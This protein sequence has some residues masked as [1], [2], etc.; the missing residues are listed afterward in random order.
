[1]ISLSD[2]VPPSVPFRCFTYPK[3]LLYGTSPSVSDPSLPLLSVPRSMNRKSTYIVPHESVPNPM[4]P[5]YTCD[6]ATVV[7]NHVCNMVIMSEI[8]GYAQSNT[9]ALIL[10]NHN[11][12]PIPPNQPALWHYPYSGL[13]SPILLLTPN[14]SS[15][16]W[17]FCSCLPPIPLIPPES[18]GVSLYPPHSIGS[19]PLFPLISST[20]RHSFKNS[21][22]TRIILISPLFP[23][24][25]LPIL[26]RAWLCELAQPCIAMHSH[27]QPYVSIRT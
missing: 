14:S 19:L 13:H 26:F 27:A 17:G 16:I 11:T 10:S 20:I 7:M 15:I 22:S 8:K 4:A 25:I 2:S 12:S 21:F 9:Q 24:H 5:V 23:P 6:S 1:M 3:T 18:L